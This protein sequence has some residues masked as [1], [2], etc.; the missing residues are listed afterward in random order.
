MIELMIVACLGSSECRD[1]PILFDAREVSL[2]TCMMSG[3]SEVARW[4]SVHPQWE[5]VRW[6]CNVAGAG[7]E[8]A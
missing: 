5:I 3:Q 8:S 7:R 4:Q 6:R 2:L 1:F